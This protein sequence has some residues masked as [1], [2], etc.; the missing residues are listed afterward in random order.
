MNT[1]INLNKKRKERDQLARKQR[2]DENAVAFGRSK[3][4]KTLEKTREEKA[5]QSLDQHKR[6]T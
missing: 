6:E 1:P 4:E 3:A 2:A 5:A